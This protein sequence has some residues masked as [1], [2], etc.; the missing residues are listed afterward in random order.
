[1][2][3]VQWPSS[4]PPKAHPPVPVLF[5]FPP[6]QH[7]CALAMAISSADMK[8]MTDTLMLMMAENNEKLVCLLVIACLQPRVNICGGV[9]MSAS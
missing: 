3:R 8:A 5:S 6:L 2:L 4:W 7:F 1:M 9:L